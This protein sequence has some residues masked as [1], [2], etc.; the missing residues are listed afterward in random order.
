MDSRQISQLLT[1]AK[2]AHLREVAELEQFAGTGH[3]P[4]DLSGDLDDVGQHP[5]DAATDTTEREVDLGLLEDVR[6]VIVE[7]DAAAQR[8]EEGT[9]GRCEECNKAIADE[10][11]QAVPWARRCQEHQADLERSASWFAA[12]PSSNVTDLD[13]ASGTDPLWDPEDDD[14]T[15]SAEEDAMHDIIE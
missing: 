12:V 8:V 4:R 1:A 13:A 7:I 15:L 9:Y 5:A 6:A 14:A 10:R 11:L 2:E 3:S